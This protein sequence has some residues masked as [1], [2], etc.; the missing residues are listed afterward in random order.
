[1]LSA[2]GAVNKSDATPVFRALQASMRA[3]NNHELN[4]LSES[5]WVHATKE[6]YR[7]TWVAQSF[8]YPTLS[9]SSGPGLR[10]VR[11]SPA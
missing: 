3:D 6:Q 10:V 7:G 5:T 8:K 9:F 2:G 1:M 11:L 4:T